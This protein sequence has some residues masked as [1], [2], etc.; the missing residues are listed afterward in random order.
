MAKHPRTDASPSDAV[1]P[2]SVAPEHAVRLHRLA[3]LE[4]DNFL[5]FLAL[6]G[7]L[8]ALDTA[9]PAW[10]A[11]AHWDVDMQPL[12]PVLTLSEGVTRSALLEAVARGLDC[13]V[14]AYDFGGRQ[15][16]NYTAEEARAELEGA[17]PDRAEIFAALMS[18]A[19]LND[20]GQVAPTP[21]CLL[22][23]QGHQHFLDR[24]AAV[25]AMREPPTR[26]SGR[27][28]VAVSETRS[29][30]EALFDP[31]ERPDLTEGFRWDPAE[32]RRYALRAADPSGDAVGLQHGANRL[33]AIALPVLSGAAVVRR[34]ELRFLA[35]GATSK[36]D[37]AIAITWPIWSC[38]ARLASIR[39]QLAHPQ[40]ANCDAY[41]DDLVSCGAAALMRAERISVGKFMNISTAHLLG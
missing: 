9:R 14:K 27:A 34:S 5:A 16:I 1:P 18:E 26:G 31:W 38:P 36:S 12:R 17:T 19:V 40:I 24:L 7:L 21:Y 29:L 30:A 11:R 6:L 10:K 41:S 25:P 22:F 8:R 3:G 35:R 2:P 4:P 13:L 37:G 33:A 23:G 39:T 32:D 28:R 15:D 20:K